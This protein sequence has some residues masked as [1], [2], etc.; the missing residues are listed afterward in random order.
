MKMKGRNLLGNPTGL[1]VLPNSNLLVTD[2]QKGCIHMYDSA[3][4]K[5]LGKL[6]VT[7]IY[8]PNSPSGEQALFLNS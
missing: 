6:D 4:G 2:S 5:Y 7:E 8:Q 3:N 1:L